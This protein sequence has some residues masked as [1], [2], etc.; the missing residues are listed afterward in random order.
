MITNP[1]VDVRWLA[2]GAS[3]HFEIP[4]DPLRLRTDFVTRPPRL[5]EQE[6]GRLW[7][8]PEQRSVRVVGVEHLAQ[9][10]LATIAAG[11]DELERAFD[12]ERRRLM[13]AKSRR[14]RMESEGRKS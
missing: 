14:L 9:P 10:L 12:E 5:S 2:A 8:Q 4:G 11:R 13:R 3:S 1:Y 7:Q 6:L